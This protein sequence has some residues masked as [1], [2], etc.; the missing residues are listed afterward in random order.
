MDK[1][2]T[3]YNNLDLGADEGIILNFIL[4]KYNVRVWNGL[5]SSE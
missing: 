4:N 2:R 1:I 5:Y 3:E